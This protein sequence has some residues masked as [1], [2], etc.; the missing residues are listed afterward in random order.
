MTI[1]ATFALRL[2][3]RLASH[4]DAAR[5]GSEP[6]RNH[7]GLNCRSKAD[8]PYMKAKSP[9]HMASATTARMEA[10]ALMLHGFDVLAYGRA[11]GAMFCRGSYSRFREPLGFK[12]ERNDNP[13]V[14]FSEPTI[15]LSLTLL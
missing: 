14:G 7:M 15:T 3:P 11:S 10:M 8:I 1:A 6:A 9:D 13:V 12:N 4:N 5:M 2:P